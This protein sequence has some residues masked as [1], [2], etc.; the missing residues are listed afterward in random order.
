VQ[1]AER[2][3]AELGAAPGTGLDQLSW[4]LIGHLQ[5]N[6]VRKA[7]QLF[8][9]IESLDSLRLAKAIDRHCAALKRTMPVL[10]EVNSGRESSKSGVMPEAL[11]ALAREVAQLPNLKLQGLMT[12]GPVESSAGGLREC[13]RLTRKLFQELEA[14][15]LPGVEMRYLSMGM[16]ASYELAI[17]EGS[18]LVRLGTRIFGPR[19]V[20]GRDA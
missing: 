14:S 19:P 20:E 5:R 1:E 2:M 11:A 10:I 6:K 9:L 12:M 13:Y 3:R 18:N 15:A 7:V 8:D 16:S 4:H 17:E